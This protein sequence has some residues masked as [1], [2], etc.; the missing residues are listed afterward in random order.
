DPRIP[1]VLLL[2]LQLFFNAV[3]VSV[4]IYLLY[5]VVRT[6]RQD[7]RHKIEMYTADAI[8]EISL[9]SRQYYRNRC[10]NDGTN[11]RAPAL[12][13]TCMALEK[14]M[15]R[16]PQQ[17]G[18]SQITAET[19]ADILN[20]FMNPISWKLTVL[21]TGLIVGGVFIINVAFGTYR[22]R[23]G[24]ED[25]SKNTNATNSVVRSRKEMVLCPQN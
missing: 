1:Y 23:S 3:I 10:S 4:V 7:V 14:C 18:K 16:D 8:Q 20:G 15:N 13:E 17:I 9:C 5:T 2:Y 12:E 24:M 22:S 6:V 25:F 21:F 11:I 19:F